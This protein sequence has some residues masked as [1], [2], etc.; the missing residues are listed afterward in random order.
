M[1]SPTQPDPVER[2][3]PCFQDGPADYEDGAPEHGHELKA[4]GS[5]CFLDDGH[6]GDHEWTP[7]CGITVTFK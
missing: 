2:F 7:D 6:E 4:C 5:T 1:T 3:I